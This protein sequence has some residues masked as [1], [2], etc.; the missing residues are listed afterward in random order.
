MEIDRYMGK[1][2]TPAILVL[3]NGEVFEGYSFGYEGDAFGEVCFNTSMTGYQEIITDPSYN[4]QIVTMTYPMIGNYGI[5]DEL[6]Q[7]DKIQASALIVKEYV[8]RA[9]NHYSKKDLSEFLKEN[10]IPGL[11]RIDTRRLVLTLRNEG[12]MRG[13]I[14]TGQSYQPEM[15]EKVK[16]TPSM[17]GLD[18]ASGVGTKEIYPFGNHSGKKFKIGVFDFGVKT[19]ILKYLDEAGFA[20]EVLPPR[21][22]L[23]EAEAKGYHCYF[24][25]NGPG[26]PEPLDY[27]VGTIRRLIEKDRPVFGICLGHQLIGLASGRKTYKLKFGHRGGNQPVRDHSTGKV[28]ITSQNHGFAVSD[29]NTAGIRVTQINLNDHTIEAFRDNEKPVLSVQ[30]HPEAS[31]GPNDAKH[32]FA[33]YYGMVEEYYRTRA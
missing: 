22:T 7:S 27:A 31:P 11:E 33:D 6:N 24:M 17:G 4:G 9:R 32:L 12:A 8:G 14:F 26:D 28:E 25:S 20:V 23:E 3:E 16:S 15:L 30:Y 13:G 21:T 19:N 10:K 1:Q 18:L 2:R 5:S 29:E